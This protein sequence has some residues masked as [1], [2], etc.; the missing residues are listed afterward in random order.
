MMTIR[1]TQ[2]LMDH[3]GERPTE[4]ETLPGSPPSLGEWYGTLVLYRRT[5][6]AL[7]VNEK[8]YYAIVV[9][10][11]ECASLFTLYIRLAQRIYDAMRRLGVADDAA[12]R[13]LDEHRGG[14]RIAPTDNRSLLGTMNGLAK[15]LE[16][17]LDQRLQHGPIREAADLDGDLNDVPHKP[18]G[19]SNARERFIELAEEAGP[20]HCRP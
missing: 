11:A 20:K 6:M 18:L 9:P 13:A 12:R 10:L 16:C 7:C 19:W 4:A 8:S 15:H 2:R 1:C 5:P 17:H 14:V 3:F